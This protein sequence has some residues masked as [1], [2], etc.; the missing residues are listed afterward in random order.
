MLGNLSFERTRT[1]PTGYEKVRTAFHLI[2]TGQFLAALTDGIIVTYF[3]WW[4]NHDHWSTPW[5]FIIVSQASR[6]LNSPR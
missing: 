3:I 5:V 2:R 6:S 4:L 1:A